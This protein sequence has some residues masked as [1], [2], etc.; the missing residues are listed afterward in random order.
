ML[1]DKNVCHEKICWN[2]KK[3]Y[4]CKLKQAQMAE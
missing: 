3:C 4:L 1:I 2:K